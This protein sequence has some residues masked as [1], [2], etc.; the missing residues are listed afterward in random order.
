MTPVYT[1]LE[2]G[3]IM[4]FVVLGLTVAYRLFNFPDLTVE[5]SF[6]LGAIGFA[7]AARDGSGI[8]LALLV[9][10]TL[11]AL[12]GA[13]TGCLHARF[14][15]NKF[16][17]G[18]IVVSI[19]YTLSLRL[20]GASNIGL[21]SSA[22]QFDQFVEY[23]HILDLPIG[24]SIFLLA[25]AGVVGALI[26]VTMSSYLGLRWRVATCNPDYAR[27]LGIGVTVSTM[28]G[29][30]VT[31][32]LAALS[33]AFLSLHQGFADVGL[34]QGVLILALASMSVGDRLLSEQRFS[35]PTFI[36]ISSIL[37]SVAYQCLVSL[38]VRA[39]LNP[40]DMK[41]ITAALVLALVIA[42]GK[43]R[44]DPFASS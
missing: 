33:G 12:A 16:L 42:R 2:M 40:I 7:I 8:L 32:S 5:G 31:N 41:L 21:L 11:G 34:G 26:G 3:L 24:K 10:V 30:A 17:A 22:T 19:S 37:G 4:S 43:R 1:G 38:A 23:A 18:I 36:I 28:L 14:H 25:V 9:A 44:D 35:I 6:L 27:T 39:G 15:I 13:L 20:M 29:L